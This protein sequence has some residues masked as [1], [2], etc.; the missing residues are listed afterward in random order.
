MA[1]RHFSNSFTPGPLH[2]AAGVR[3]SLPWLP[4]SFRRYLELP[5]FLTVEIRVLTLPKYKKPLERGGKSHRQKTEYTIYKSKY[6]SNNNNKKFL[7]TP[8][9]DTDRLAFQH[10]L[11]FLSYL[12]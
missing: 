11:A 3:P 5:F 10:R 9:S 1:S 8:L 4:P 2:L 12:I 7:S 6:L